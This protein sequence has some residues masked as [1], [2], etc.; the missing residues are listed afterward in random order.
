MM[1]GWWTVLIAV[2]FLTVQWI[3][4]LMVIS[5]QPEWVICFWGPGITW[6][7]IQSIWLWAI[8]AAK[9]GLWFL[10]LVIVWLTVWVRL[11]AKK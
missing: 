1:A 10:I 2:V 11:L 9:I 3:V 5:R 4:Y 7:D 8:V 6:D